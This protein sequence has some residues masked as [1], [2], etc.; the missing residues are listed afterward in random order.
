MKT[1]TLVIGALAVVVGAPVLLAAAVVGTVSLL[2]R[3][4]GTLVSAGHKREY[5]LY[6]P[7][8]YDRTR[9][10][11]LVISLHA[12]MNWPAFQQRLTQWNTVADENGFLVVY[13][14]GLGTGPKT[15]YMEGWR[16]PATMP[17]VRFIA[18]LLDTLEAHYNIDPTRIYADGMSNGGGMA[19]A[20]SC[21]LSGRIAAVGEVS[22]AQSLPSSWCAD[23]TPVPLLEMHGTADPFVPYD[24]AGAGAITP[25]PFP[26]I[27]RWVAD[28][29]R[30]NRCAPKAADSTV[31]ADVVRTAY[32]H[33][34]RGADVVLY[35]MRGAGHQWYG[36]RPLPR[37]IVGP[38]TNSVD[39]TRLL[40][41]FYRAH[42]LRRQ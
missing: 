17:D 3:T 28:W 40:W 30:R 34:A 22:A 41:A 27:R 21:T 25:R 1:R 39:A 36:G 20:L 13:P 33:C 35:T 16:H 19:L 8:S 37:W 32:T 10:A 6:V 9:P 29:A 14:G 12:A 24:G 18:A 31:A 5:L 42:P 23:S 7:K 2:D 4:N 11:P 26:N 15:W 38:T